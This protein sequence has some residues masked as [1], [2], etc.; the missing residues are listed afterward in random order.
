MMKKMVGILLLAVLAAA[1]VVG[2]ASPQP[3][4][5]TP[6]AD[7]ARDYTGFAGK[8]MAVITGVLTVT[9][10]EK[11]GAIPVEYKDS[12]S[13]AEDVRQGRVAGYMHALT[14]VQVMAA[15]MP[16]FEVIPVPKEIFSAQIG[17]F[18]NNQAVV[19]R[20]N[21]FLAQMEADGTL[22]EM[23]ERWFSNKLDLDA[24]IPEIANTGENG[25]FS[26][27]ICSD[28]IPYVYVGA[29]GEYSG[30]SVELALRFGAHEGKTIEFTDMAFDGLVP[31][32]NTAKAELGIANVAITEE[33]KKSVLFTSPFFNEGHGILALKQ[34]G[35][36][37]VSTAP[38]AAAT[39]TYA[40]FVGKTLGIPTGYVLDALIEEDLSGTVAHYSE[41][42][43]GLEDVRQGRIDGFMTDLSIARVIENQ[44]ENS[45][46][47]A[48]AV[49]EELFSGPLGAISMD[50]DTIERF[51]AFLAET[52]ADGTLAQMQQYWIEDNPGA[53]PPMPGIPTADT[54]EVL[55]IAIGS[56]SIPFCYIGADG[57]V[58]GL[59]AELMLRFAARENL[60][61][62]FTTME[63]SALIPYITAEKAD[64]GIDAITITEERKASVLFT[65]P[66]YFDHIGILALKPRDAAQQ[67][68]GG[69]IEWLQTG[70]E[71]NLVTES[72]WKMI[73]DG[74]AVT[75]IIALCAQF[76]GT[77]LGALVCWLLTRKNRFVRWL[78][79]LYCGLIRGLPMVV[80]LMITYYI[81]FGN[82]T[83][84]SIIIAVAAF[85]IVTGAS[86]AETLRGAIATVDPVEI[87]AARSLGFSA[88]RA[89][90]AV[91]LP[92]AIRRAL[93]GYTGGFVELVKAT[94]IVG[95]VAIQDLMRAADIIRS[96]TYDA[97]FPLLFVGIIYLIITT[98]CI[99]LF[100]LIVKK[101]N[102]GEAE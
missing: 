43:A 44:P 61:P 24:P 67:A 15:Q 80:L 30:Y 47:A 8:D 33:R 63:F 72:R 45:D 23:Q 9:T 81:I 20:F 91:T 5:A 7:A 62:E 14:A 31:Y 35:A 87:E 42:S 83:I 51:N 96:R 77:V 26:V 3:Q 41:T 11:I 16:E 17:A 6:A 52:E 76:L 84:S 10:S 85:T 22:A 60:R 66:F 56:G 34:G 4:S 40:D 100:K 32:V 36:A 89:F 55:Q 29:N 73:V 65:Q 82:S 98:I 70:I 78:G 48:V 19:D 50:A 1:L 68:Q 79:S 99:Q 64:I 95:Y 102:G 86:V 2:D 58:M 28:A 46:L 21:T 49:P 59:C 53:D 90:C 74:L 93:P 92:Q 57:E 101:I 69:F 97:Y 12:A 37:P 88:F 75:I 27:A 18:S 39:R 71:R 25:T 54:D 13:A 38:A 94:A